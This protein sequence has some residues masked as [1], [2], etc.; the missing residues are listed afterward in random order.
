MHGMIT[1][2]ALP[3][4]LTIAITAIIILTTNG[5]VICLILDDHGLRK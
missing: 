2:V 1:R 3:I 5:V 4:C